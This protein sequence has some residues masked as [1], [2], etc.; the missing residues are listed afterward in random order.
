MEERKGVRVLVQAAIQ[1]V[2]ELDYSDVHFV[3]CGNKNNEADMYEQLLV[4]KKARAHVTFAGHRSDI[5]R[6]DARLLS[7]CEQ[8]ITN[9][10][11]KVA[12]KYVNNSPQIIVSLQGYFFTR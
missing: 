4:G 2:D 5:Q 1:L 8:K 3:I 11:E 10:K 9:Y 12:C 6:I 7:L